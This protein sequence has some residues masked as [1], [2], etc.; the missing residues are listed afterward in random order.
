M[1][2]DTSAIMAILNDEPE[3]RSFNEAIENLTFACYRPPGL[4]K[5][6]SSWKTAAVMKASGT[7]IC[8]WPPPE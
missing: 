7:S 4:S 6:Q 5:R 8:G 2:I 1:I 3:R